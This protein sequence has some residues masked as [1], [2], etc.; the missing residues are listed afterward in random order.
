V[1]VRDETLPPVGEPVVIPE[2]NAFE[3]L[4]RADRVLDARGSL[5]EDFLE[6]VPLRAI[7]LEGE[8]DLERAIAFRDAQDFHGSIIE[9][10]SSDV[11][12]GILGRMEPWEKGIYATSPGYLRAFIEAIEGEGA[13]LARSFSPKGIAPPLRRYG[14][15]AIL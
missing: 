12:H 13:R 10:T 7:G 4:A 5:H 9:K 3:F 2:N 6:L 1:L 14:L 11:I 8:D 15:V